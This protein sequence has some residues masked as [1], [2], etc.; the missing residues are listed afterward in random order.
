MLSKIKKIIPNPVFSF[1]HFLL[2]FW[3]N[4]F[5]R[6]PSLKM[7]LIGI[8][9]TKGKTTSAFLA[10]Q[11]LKNCEKK[12]ALSS[13]LFF[14]VGEKVEPNLTKMGM[15]GRFFLPRFLKKALQNKVE[16]VI[17]ETTSEGIMQHRSRF[18]KYKTVVFTGLAPEHIE[19]HGSFEKY[20]KTKEKLFQ[21]CKEN[22][23]L[24]LDNPFS[25][26]FL[27]HPAK[28]K[29][30]VTFDSKKTKNNFNQVSH[31]IFGKKLQN[32][33]IKI[34]EFLNGQPVFQKE[35]SFDFLGQFNA[36]NLLIA[37]TIARSIGLDFE[38]LIKIIKKLV[39][40]KGRIE[41]IKDK[42]INFRLFLD[43]AHEP[44]SLSSVL[45][46]GKEILPPKKRLICLIGGQGGGR[47]KW[48]RKA[49]GKIAGRLC[50]IVIVATEDPYDEDM[51][52]I[53]EDVLSGVLLN[54]KM[55]EKQNVFSFLDRKEGLKKAILEAQEGDVVLLCGKG[56]EKKMCVKGKMI[57]WDEEKEVRKII[58][59]L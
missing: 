19:R 13:T 36:E 32:Q 11:F 57:D 8:T 21:K 9:G 50:D 35:T 26:D 27:T 37:F 29:W 46:A 17:L 40:P 20:K 43:Y 45:S 39:L 2:A 59:K 12:T 41:E 30:G 33:K 52:S 48:K 47:D 3:G 42:K 4:V 44:L 25:K 55:K 58:K 16:Y 10:Y 6:N 23:I 5:Y 56:G 7:H 38:T 53:N 22:H 28:E 54:K 18:L 34:T 31:L 51:N 24:N 15:P 1:Y 49:M 14:A